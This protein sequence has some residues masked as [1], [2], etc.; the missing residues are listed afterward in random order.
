MFGENMVQAC[1]FGFSMLMLSLLFVFAYMI[2][3]MRDSSSFILSNMTLCLTFFRLVLYNIIYAGV[4][5][6]L[7]FLVLYFDCDFRFGCG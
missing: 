7:G 5:A 6:P 4:V 3:S 1:H 2:S